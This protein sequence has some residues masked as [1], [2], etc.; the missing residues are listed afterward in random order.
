[1]SEAPTLVGQ[2]S[3][4]LREAFGKAIADVA[5]SDAAIVVL[6]ADVAGGTGA[7]HFRSRHPQRFI[8]CGIAEQNMISVAAGMAHAGLKPFVTTF[9]VFMLRGLEQVRLS[10]AY[11]GNNVKLIASHPGLDVGP[12]GASAQCMEDL[13]CM[14]AI[15]GMVVLS[16]GDAHE[17]AAA[18][19]A[20][21]QYH[22]PAYMRTGRS[23]CP[24]IFSAEPDFEI[25]KGRI[26]REGSDVTLVG[27]G[28]MTR[29][30]LVAAERLAASGI[31]ARVIH[32]PTIKP[33]DRELLTA[34]ARSTRLMVTC[35]DHNIIGGLGSAVAE[36]LSELALVPLRRI[37]IADVIGTSG[38]PDELACHYGLDADSVH[39]QV[40]SMVRELML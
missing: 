17:V 20:L 15:P 32:M 28:V 33:I 35:E 34:A 3:D 10:V 8:Q 25:G 37:G 11:S 39:D 23:P 21:A 14:R 27:C 36:V 9:A 18:T 19:R 31:S 4:S 13:A 12:D 29:R 6:D 2:Q 38:E 40:L 30:A 24:N 7:H 22:G 16:P 1:M 26:L 5:A